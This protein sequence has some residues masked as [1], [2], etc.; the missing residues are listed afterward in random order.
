M[1][2]VRSE[3]VANVHEFSVPKLHLLLCLTRPLSKQFLLPGQDDGATWPQRVGALL[4]GRQDPV[5]MSI[6]ALLDEVL[7]TKSC[8]VTS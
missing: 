7:P 2:N 6:P 8:T 3:G 1:L 5:W 4:F